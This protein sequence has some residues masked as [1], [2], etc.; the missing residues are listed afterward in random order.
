MN[1]LTTGLGW[2]T[3]NAKIVFIGAAIACFGIFLW[4][5][6]SKLEELGTLRTVVETQVDT[7]RAKEEIIKGMI[8]I[9]NANNRVISQR[10]KELQELSTKLDGILENLGDDIDNEAPTSLQ[11]LLRRLDKK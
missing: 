9:N 6:N 3:S 2:L 4:N 11:E 8:A 10:D 5:Y 1:I 7:I